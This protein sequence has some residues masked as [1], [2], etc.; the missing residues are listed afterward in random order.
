MSDLRELRAA[1]T[2][3]EARFAEDFVRHGTHS[4]AARTA[5]YKGSASTLSR[6]GRKVAARAHVQAYV[7]ALRT[8][9]F[10]DPKSKLEL[11]RDRLELIGLGQ[12]IEQPVGR[13]GKLKLRPAAASTQVKA[14]ETLVRMHGGL[15]P[16]IRVDIGPTVRAE[17]EAIRRRVSPE[18]FAEVIAA[19]ESLHGESEESA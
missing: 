1:C 12:E 17:L 18:V 14:L 6:T 7:D 15:D 19:I 8:D 4:E 9:T 11:Y 16:R 10:G 5:G 13:G 3:K 2:E